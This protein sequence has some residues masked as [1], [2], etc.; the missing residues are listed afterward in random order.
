M[1][2]KWSYSLTTEEQANS[3]SYIVI[4]FKFN[5]SSWVY[6]EIASYT[7]FNGRESF[8]DPSDPRY[9]VGRPIASDSATLLINDVKS[10]SDESLYKIEYHLSSGKINESEVNLTVLGKCLFLICADN[11]YCSPTN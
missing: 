5:S 6:A 3:N 4:W 2:L 10:G 11:V 1:A 7:V 8:G 9:A